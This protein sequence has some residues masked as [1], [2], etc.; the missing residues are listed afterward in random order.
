MRVVAGIDALD[1]PSLFAK[2]R[3]RIVLHAAIY[4]PF[5]DSAPHRTGL[6]TALA[7]ESFKRLDIVALGCA[8]PW[9]SPFM[10]ALRFDEDETRHRRIIAESRQFLDTLT[11]GYPEKVRVY[12]VSTFPCLP[13]LI[14]DNTILSGQY[15]H[16]EA[17]AAHGLWSVLEADVDTLFDWAENG[18]LPKNASAEAIAAYRLVSECHHAMTGGPR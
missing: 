17:Y 16:C 11:T 18:G 14:I 3:K 5:A 6:E 1:L 8:T 15:A 7:K 2:A 10:H 12:A 9:A 13:I 4:G